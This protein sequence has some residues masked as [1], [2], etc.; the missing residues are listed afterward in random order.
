MD[1]HGSLLAAAT[2]DGCCVAAGPRPVAVLHLVVACQPV[3]AGLDQDEPELAI[4]VLAVALQMLAH[5]HGLLDQEIQVLWDV[6]GQAAALQDTQDLAAS[7]GADLGDAVLVTQ[8]HT[9][10]TGGHTL[11]GQLADL[12]LHLWAQQSSSGTKQLLRSDA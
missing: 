5:G 6:R 11:L 7:D 12:V 10:G 2:G 4:L 1:T 3:D 9:N 8:Q